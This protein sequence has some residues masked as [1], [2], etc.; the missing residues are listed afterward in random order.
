MPEVSLR[1]LSGALGL[2]RGGLIKKAEAVTP[3]DVAYGHFQRTKPCYARYI[4]G[5][6]Y[7][8]GI[9]KKNDVIL[10][11]KPDMV[12]LVTGGYAVRFP[13]TDDDGAMERFI[14]KNGVTYII[15]DTCYEEARR[16][17]LPFISRRKDR[18][19]TLFDDSNGTALLRYEGKG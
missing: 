14:E 9:L 12:S 10:A 4:A 1:R 16:F 8:K 13:F 15:A 3:E 18:F 19:Q 17:L 7:L 6:F 2:L 11:R 5:A